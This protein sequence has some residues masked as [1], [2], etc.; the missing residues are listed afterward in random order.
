MLM[1]AC[2]ETACD[3]LKDHCVGIFPQAQQIVSSLLEPHLEAWWQCVRM[4]KGIGESN[5]KPARGMTW[6]EEPGTNEMH[7]VAMLAQKQ[8]QL[9]FGPEAVHVCVCANLGLLD[10]Y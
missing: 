3:A 4:C 6:R 10:S 9:D 5:L 8:K 2:L 1:I 7:N